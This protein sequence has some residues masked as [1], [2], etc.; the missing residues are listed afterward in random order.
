[1]ERAASKRHLGTDL[2]KTSR[3]GAAD[4]PVGA[5]V[6]LALRDLTAE[7]LTRPGVA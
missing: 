4:V 5:R 6:G 2:P 7:V 3:S 1:M